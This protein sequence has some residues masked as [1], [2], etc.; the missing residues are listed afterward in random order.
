MQRSSVEMQKNFILKKSKKCLK[1]Y[2]PA[3]NKNRAWEKIMVRGSQIEEQ[4]K[5]PEC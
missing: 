4:K 2:I 3:K 1:N 5:N